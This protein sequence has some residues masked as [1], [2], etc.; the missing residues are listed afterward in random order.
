M[1]ARPAAAPVPRL[2]RDEQTALQCVNAEREEN[3]LPPL[4]VD[5]VLVEVARQHS[6]DMARQGYFSH[7]APGP[8]GPSP[9]D[10][11]AEALGR[12]PGTVVG[13]NLATCDAPMI[14]LIHENMMASPGHRA[15][16][17][18]PEYVSVGVGIW[19]ADDGRV[20]VTEMF[21][22]A[23]PQTRR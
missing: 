22:G 15:N 23:L 8:D 10:R 7:I 6:A 18:D 2:T 12:K 19:T 13:E 20:W 3:G 21:R 1:A 11:Y 5:P 17:L 4:S 9:L 14:G 16:I